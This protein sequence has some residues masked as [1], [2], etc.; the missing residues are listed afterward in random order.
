MVTMLWLIQ[1]RLV[2][3]PVVYCIVW[4]KSYWFTHQHIFF[5]L[6]SSYSRP[7]LH[8]ISEDILNAAVALVPFKSQLKTYLFPCRSFF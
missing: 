2:D 7:H 5:N 3:V 4:S 1:C 8:T 6:A